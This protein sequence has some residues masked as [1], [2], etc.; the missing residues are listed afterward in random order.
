MAVTLRVIGRIFYS[1]SHPARG[2]SSGFAH[3]KGRRYNI[4]AASGRL[5]CEPLAVVAAPPRVRAKRFAGVRACTASPGQTY[6]EPLATAAAAELLAGSLDAPRAVGRWGGAGGGWLRR[7]GPAAQS[8]RRVGGRSSRRA[9]MI[10]VGGCQRRWAGAAG[11][12]VGGWLRGSG[13]LARPGPG[14]RAIEC[15]SRVSCPCH[16]TPRRS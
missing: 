14:R 13:A 3:T 2:R 8:G 11:A 9:E 16:P 5:Y 1:P 10:G 7:G 12:A 4:V 6:S 15:R